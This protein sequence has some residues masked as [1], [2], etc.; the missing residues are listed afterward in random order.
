MLY[1]QQR[2]NGMGIW[3]AFT[4]SLDFNIDHNE[5]LNLLPQGRLPDAWRPVGRVRV[6]LVRHHHPLGPQPHH[7]G[8]LVSVCCTIVGR[9]V[10][11]T[12]A[13]TVGFFPLC[14]LPLSLSCTGLLYFSFSTYLPSNKDS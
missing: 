12:V 8:K 9:K 3:V 13:Q 1:F 6:H 11:A 10:W 14:A 2:I 5:N 4:A 7:G